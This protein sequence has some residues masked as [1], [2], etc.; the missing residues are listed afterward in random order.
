MTSEEEA[1]AALQDYIH[2][3]NGFEGAKSWNSFVVYEE[4]D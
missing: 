1:R 2:E 4:S 3:R